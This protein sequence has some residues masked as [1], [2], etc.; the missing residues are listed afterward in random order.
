MKPALF[1][2]TNRVAIV[3]G[4]A[5]GLGRAL[6]QGLAAQG[7]GV[8][9]CDIDGDGAQMTAESIRG[10]GG[11]SRARACGCRRCRQLRR[12]GPVTR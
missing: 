9:A 3:T 6:A 4:A 12:A 2:L 10:T 5:R 7:A 1:D 11:E 8:V